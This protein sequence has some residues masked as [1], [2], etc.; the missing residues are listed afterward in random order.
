MKI[1]TGYNGTSFGKVYLHNPTYRTQ[2]QLTLL[3]HNEKLYCRS[4]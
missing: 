4:E 1:G 2:E 3:V